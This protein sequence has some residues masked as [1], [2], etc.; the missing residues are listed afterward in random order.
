MAVPT[1]RRAAVALAAIALL[2]GA[3]AAQEAAAPAVPAPTAAPV[4]LEKL[5]TV[6]EK[7]RAGIDK[8]SNLVSAEGKGAGAIPCGRA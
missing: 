3:A 7:T 1:W 5:D 6:V 2:A 8:A 4:A